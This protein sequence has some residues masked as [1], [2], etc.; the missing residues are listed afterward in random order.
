[1]GGPKRALVAMTHGRPGEP[2]AGDRQS[3][4]I[5]EI[6]ST[7]FPSPGQ[8]CSWWPKAW[9]GWWFDERLENGQENA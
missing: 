7:A 1:M 4:L 3:P 9:A 8:E 6:G 2:M 5:G